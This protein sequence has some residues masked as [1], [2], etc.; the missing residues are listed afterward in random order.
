MLIV[1]LQRWSQDG[2]NGGAGK[3]EKIVSGGDFKSGGFGGSGGAGG[4]AKPL[5]DSFIAGVAVMVRP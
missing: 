5:C 3:G 4:R 2:G 1:G